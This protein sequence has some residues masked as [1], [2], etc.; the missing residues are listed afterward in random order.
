MNAI[1]FDLNYKTQV[2]C[3]EVLPGAGGRMGAA[4]QKLTR[5]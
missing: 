2:T 1:D 5:A 3:L 4:E